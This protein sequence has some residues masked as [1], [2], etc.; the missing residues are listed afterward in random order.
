MGRRGVIPAPATVD[1]V[2]I[3]ATTGGLP[4]RRLEVTP[5]TP[6]HVSA[7]AASLTTPGTWALDV[8]AVHGGT[9]TTEFTLEVPIR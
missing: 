7:L 5:I 1:A 3:E 4:P 6:T 9:N 2:E 8:R